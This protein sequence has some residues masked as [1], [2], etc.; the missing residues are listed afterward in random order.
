MAS[1]RLKI[2]LVEIQNWKRAGCAASQS[3]MLVSTHDSA[4]PAREA[5][6][7]A[8][9]VASRRQGADLQGWGGSGRLRVGI[10]A[11]GL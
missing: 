9:R 1:I 5:S 2:W 4:E 7:D 8:T 10:T 6:T 11:S 3:R